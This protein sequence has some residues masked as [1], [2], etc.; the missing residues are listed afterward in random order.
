MKSTN[1]VNSGTSLL[2]LRV[3]TETSLLFLWAR[4]GYRIHCSLVLVRL[5]VRDIVVRRGG[6]VFGNT[7]PGSGNVRTVG[8]RTFHT[9]DR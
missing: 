1:P 4:R 7:T 6:L 3:T 8:V 5:R 2:E 9:S